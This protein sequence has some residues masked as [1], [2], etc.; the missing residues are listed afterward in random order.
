VALQ[1]RKAEKVSVKN[2]F[3]HVADDDK[4]PSDSELNLPPPL[5]IIPPSVSAD[6]LQ[7][8][9]MDYQNFRA[10]KA[11]GAK[12]EVSE[13][14][15]VD[16]A[17]DLTL[18]SLD[19]AVPPGYQPSGSV[20][21]PKALK[22]PMTVGT[23]ARRHLATSHTNECVDEGFQN[24]PLE[25]AWACSVKNT[26]VHVPEGG[27]DEDGEEPIHLPPPLD[28]I[29]PYVSEEKL[30][31]FRMDYQNFRTG[32][33][34][35]AKGEVEHS[36]ADDLDLAASDEVIARMRQG[37]PEFA[38]PTPEATPQYCASREPPLPPACFLTPS[39]YSPFDDRSGAGS[40][41]KPQGKQNRRR[42]NRG[43]GTAGTSDPSMIMQPGRIA[44]PQ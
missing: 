34:V 38:A 37:A 23:Q 10:G 6:K 15:D 21:F 41:S 25:G 24:V 42:R 17:A 2:T 14:V 11:V 20:V 28:I 8:Y 16:L 35:G 12:G 31:H 18:E 19:L 9:R 13:S 1:P 36:V 39:M 3:V 26:F 33:A 40:S 4:A 29:P 32:K 7:A 44:S 27:G 5:D 22:E 30:E 43:P